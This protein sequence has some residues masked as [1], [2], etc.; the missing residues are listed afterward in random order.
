[1]KVRL[2]GAFLGLL[3]IPLLPIPMFAAENEASTVTAPAPQDKTA[4]VSSAEFERLK[5]Q[6]ATQQQQIEQLRLA[7]E[8]QQKILN[9]GLAPAITPAVEDKKTAFSLPSS[10]L[11]EVA[12]T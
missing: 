6:L 11:G 1:M 2:L 12:S 8:A 4:P 5:A 3:A 9:R 7:L 10:K